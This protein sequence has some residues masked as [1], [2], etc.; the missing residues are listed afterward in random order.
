[1]PDLHRIHTPDASPSLS[2]E[3]PQRRAVHRTPW[4]AYRRCSRGPASFIDAPTA[5]ATSVP[6][7]RGA[8][9][10]DRA[11]QSS[12]VNPS[13]RAV[14]TAG[15]TR[16][17]RPGRCQRRPAGSSRAA[18][19][20][21]FMLEHSRV[22]APSRDSTAANLNAVR[23]KKSVQ[24]REAGGALLGSEKW[25]PSGTPNVILPSVWRGHQVR[26]SLVFSCF[27]WC[28][29]TELNRRPRDFQSR[30]LPTELPGL[31]DGSPP[32]GLVSSSSQGLPSRLRRPR[33]GTRPQVPGI[34][35]VMRICGCAGPRG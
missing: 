13:H 23:A 22:P 8:E 35:P 5:S 3:P 1:M 12:R 24:H 34:R 7:R 6:R 10:G 4:R 9:R 16:R 32:K 31:G 18:R 17:P 27:Y 28:P 21:E 14:S 25:N 33:R 29:G 19:S 2:A 15:S 20:L 11:E 26:K 30:A